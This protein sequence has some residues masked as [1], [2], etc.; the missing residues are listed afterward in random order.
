MHCLRTTLPIEAYNTSNRRAVADIAFCVAAYAN[1]LPED[2][3]QTGPLT[4]NISL[5]TPALPSAA[6]IRRTMEE[7]RGWAER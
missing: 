5:V 7:A 4:R 3:I 1:G 6:Y 2:R